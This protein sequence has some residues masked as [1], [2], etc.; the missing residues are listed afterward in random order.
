MQNVKKTIEFSNMGEQA[1]ISHMKC[2]KHVKNAEIIQCFSRQ[3]KKKNDNNEIST[4]HMPNSSQI[5]T[6]ETKETQQ[7]T[8]SFVPKSSP[9]RKAEIL[10][11]LKSIVSN[12]S[13]NSIDG[14]SQLFQCMFTDSEI[15]KDFQL[16]RTKLTY[17]TNFG[18]A[19]YFHRPLIDEL[20]N[21]NYYSL[22]FDESLN[23]FSRHVKWT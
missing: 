4:V 8:L 12:W 20:N 5:Q 2:K 7:L 21:C 17:I 9:S 1:L 3:T 19:P 22:S 16:S 13:A 18:I 10:F 23:D 14:M 15:A 6:N 11:T